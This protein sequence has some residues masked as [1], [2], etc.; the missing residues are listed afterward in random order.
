MD[1]DDLRVALEVAR[2]G[3]IAGAARALG[4]AHTTV[5]R[6]INAFEERAGVRFFERT[7]AGYA[8][9]DAG[10]ALADMAQELEAKVLGLERA[11]SGQDARLSGEVTVTTMEPLGLKLAALLQGLRR[12]HPGIAVRLH[13]SNAAVD[14]AR[15]EADI[16]LR[17]SADPGDALVGRR[18][19][20]L[21]FAVYA[22]RDRA[23]RTRALRDA[24]WI[25]FDATLA[26]SPQGRWETANVPPGR[27]AFRTNSRAV[28]LE[29]VAAGAGVGVLPCGLAAQAPDLIALSDALPE[30][31]VPLWVLTH[32]DLA[33]TPRVRAVVDFLAEAV[34]RE[35]DL[36]ERPQK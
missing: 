18:L 22:T 34:T 9:T 8:P 25:A 23:E 1:W 16:A 35:R 21:A 20:S 3:S 13:V 5:Y 15:R 31:T 27:V 32:P 14:L 28:F 12:A 19:C 6:R 24:D 11:L 2:T 30:L 36:L 17:A 7:A 29:W 33:Q 26:Q 10:R 4:V